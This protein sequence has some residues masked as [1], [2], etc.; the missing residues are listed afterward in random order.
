MAHAQQLWEWKVWLWGEWNQ[1]KRYYR[2]RK[3][4]LCRSVSSLCLVERG[5]D[6]EQEITE[7]MQSEGEFLFKSNIKT[8]N[9]WR[10]LFKRWQHCTRRQ[11]CDIHSYISKPTENITLKYTLWK[12]RRYRSGF[13]IYKRGSR[14]DQPSP[15]GPLQAAGSAGPPW[16]TTERFSRSARSEGSDSPRERRGFSGGTAG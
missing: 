3:I 4:N 15:H 5:E 1:M 13:F 12:M 9:W 16:E 7:G 14:S 2:K 8:G 10:Q 11:S 6:E